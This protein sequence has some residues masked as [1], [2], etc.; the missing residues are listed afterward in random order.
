MHARTHYFFTCAADELLTDA[1][2]HWWDPAVPLPTGRSRE[3]N[4]V[5][6]QLVF[7]DCPAASNL[8]YLMAAASPMTLFNDYQGLGREPNAAFC[9]E[10]YKTG[11][12]KEHWNLRAVVRTTGKIQ[13]GEQILVDYGGNNLSRML[14]KV[15]KYLD[16]V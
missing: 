15:I 12:N 14:V 11:D 6:Y 5:V 4:H 16:A 3:N 9:T 1:S 7:T 10:T 13:A 2:G 8:V